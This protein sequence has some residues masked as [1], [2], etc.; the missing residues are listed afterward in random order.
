MRPS[1]RGGECSKNGLN[2]FFDVLSNTFGVYIYIDLPEL[3]KT[4]LQKMQW[5][6]FSCHARSQ[7]AASG[8]PPTHTSM[9]GSTKHLLS[10]RHQI[11][12]ANIDFVMVAM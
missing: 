8:Y 11:F 10:Y 2:I 12:E 5:Q 3:Q 6:L 9:L 7:H 1:S 4:P